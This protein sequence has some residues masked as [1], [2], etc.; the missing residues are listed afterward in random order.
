MKL[1]EEKI[2]LLLVTAPLIAEITMLIGLFIIL[3]FLLIHFGIL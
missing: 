2:H 1:N 3:F